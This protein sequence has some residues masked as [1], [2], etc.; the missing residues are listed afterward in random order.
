MTK[1]VFTYVAEDV[2][3]LKRGSKE[4]R[5]ILKLSDGK[6]SVLDTKTDRKTRI[7]EKTLRHDYTRVSDRVKESA[8]V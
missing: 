7:S 3:Q 4:I 2:L 8:D 5:L 6:W 1:T